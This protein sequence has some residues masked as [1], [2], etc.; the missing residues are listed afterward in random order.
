VEYHAKAVLVRDKEKNEHER[1]PHR[2]IRLDVLGTGLYVRVLFYHFHQ[3][4]RKLR[5]PC[6]SWVWDT[7]KPVIIWLLI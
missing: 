3:K 2:S 6:T 5:Y 4:L 1:L 7:I